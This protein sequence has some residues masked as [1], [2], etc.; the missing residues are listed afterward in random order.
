[1]NTAELLTQRLRLVYRWYERMVNPDTGM[2]EYLYLPQTGGFVREKSPIR[3]IAS[4]WDAELL[5][6]FLGRREL[7]PLVRKSLAHYDGYLVD[8][9]GYMILDSRRL[10]EPSS[11]AH[12]AFL[13]L[14]LLCAPPPIR[15][16]QISALA[17]GILRQQRRDGSYKV[18]F[19]D[20]P[21]AGEELY[22]GEAMLALMEAYRQ[23]PEAR[24]LQSV[25]RGF[26]FY[27]TQYYA[28]DRV[29]EDIL[30]F[31][32]NWQSQ[33]CRRLFECA[34]SPSL[35]QQVIDYVCRVHDQI[36]DRGFYESVERRPGEQF[37]VEVACALEGLNEAYALA[38]ASD[39]DRAERYRRCICNGLKYLLGLQCTD[40]GSVRER[41]GFGMSLND[42]AQRIDVTGH[43]ASAFIKSIGNGI[44]CQW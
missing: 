14:A 41:G 34:R 15:T 32:A 28:H 22:A 10:Q 13:A 35:K 29:S 33:A 17:E 20:M 40:D 12:S 4:V 11:I 26:S 27:N 21:D 9:D 36:A 44:D 38:S 3:D 8:R 25:E 39:G 30:V 19:D 18:Y 23:L 1:M 37:C 5:G 42:G 24:Y 7:G 2:F 31:F 43:A 16:R 6:N